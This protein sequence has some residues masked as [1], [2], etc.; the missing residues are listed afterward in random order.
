M[1]GLSPLLIRADASAKIGAG[2]LMRC[3]ALAQH[4]QKER[5]EVIVAA[6]GLPENM[7]KRL[8]SEGICYKLISAEPGTDKDLNQTI[9]I[10]K[11]VGAKH[12]VIDGYQFDAGYQSRIRDVG[13]RQLWIDDYAH[14]ERYCA[15]IVLNQNIYAKPSLYEGKYN[16]D[17]KLLMGLDYVLLRQEFLSHKGKSK[18]V[19]DICTNLL[20][21]LGG[22]DEPNMTGMV[23]DA[24]MMLENEDLNVKVIAGPTNLHNESLIRKCEQQKSRFALLS[25]IADMPQLLDWADLAISAAGSTCWEMMYMGLPSVL[26]EIAEN[27][28][29]IAKGLDQAGVMKN[30]GWFS[31]LNTETIANAIHQL[32]KNKS[33]REEMIS[34]GYG[35]VDGNGRARVF[36]S[37]VS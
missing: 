8:E 25:N 16:R 5:G 9:Q 10:V 20:V 32:I 31:D 22:S 23:I 21:T 18:S 34:R 4:W 3:L 27:Q 30:L 35:L 19:R 7:M 24:L 29:P 14:A 11:E 6:I 13:I 1:D 33:R 28:S 2:H 37:L 15:D 12:I 17:V 36:E 26:I